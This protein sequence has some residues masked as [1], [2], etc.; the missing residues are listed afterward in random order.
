MLWTSLPVR[1]WKS[2]RR[3]TRG[4]N[5]S[6]GLAGKGTASE[7][8][9]APCVFHFKQ[10]SG[11]YCRLSRYRTKLNNRLLKYCVRESG[12]F[13]HTNMWCL[14]TAL[15]PWTSPRSDPIIYACNVQRIIIS[16]TEQM[17]FLGS[18]L[19]SGTLRAIP[20]AV[21]IS[22][23]SEKVRRGS[24]GDPPDLNNSHL[25]PSVAECCTEIFREP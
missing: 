23:G 2:M 7:H 15:D 4:W 10:L 25:V 17:L 14:H 20:I 9:P 3:V 24:A 8:T 22:A 16:L 13:P 1:T 18:L 5:A 12:I 6:C 19:C 11:F 21:A